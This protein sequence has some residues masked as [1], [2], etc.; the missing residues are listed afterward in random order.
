MERIRMNVHGMK[1]LCRFSNRL[2]NAG[3][4]ENAG[5]KVPVSGLQTLKKI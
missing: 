2:V 4:V 5:V 1:I 3:S